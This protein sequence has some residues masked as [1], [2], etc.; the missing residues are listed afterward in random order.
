MVA[1]IFEQFG[2]AV[3]VRE[4]GGEDVV[5][6][7]HDVRLARVG[8]HYVARAEFRYVA[9]DRVEAD[10]HIVQPLEFFSC[11]KYGPRHQPKHNLCT[12]DLPHLLCFA[13]RWEKSNSGNV[14]CNSSTKDSPISY[15]S[16][17]FTLLSFLKG[18][19]S[20]PRRFFYNAG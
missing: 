8:H 19:I 12:H 5:G 1:L 15:V 18:R 13:I 3:G 2:D 20:I 10:A 4:D 7:G 14:V 11:Q 16:T 6:H 9:H 17:T